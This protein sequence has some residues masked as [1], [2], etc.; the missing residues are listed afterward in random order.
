MAR[1]YLTIVHKFRDTCML[2]VILDDSGY[3]WNC[4]EIK[5]RWV[6][7]GGW[8]SVRKV[9]EYHRVQGP[10]FNTRP[11]QVHGLKKYR[12]HVTVPFVC[13]SFIVLSTR[14]L[15]TPLFQIHT[16]VSINIC[17]TWCYWYWGNYTPIS[18]PSEQQFINSQQFHQNIVLIK[19]SCVNSVVQNT[20]THLPPG[21]NGRYFADGIFKY[22]FVNE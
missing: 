7:W 10:G 13:Y 3:A 5:T 17:F 12:V 18:T 11:C 8:Q 1:C 21:P 9:H 6:R 22:I 16:L 4:G 19:V 14:R 20:L 2:M 15:R